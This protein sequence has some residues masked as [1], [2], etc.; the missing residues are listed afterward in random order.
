[1][2]RDVVWTKPRWCGVCKVGCTVVALGH[3]ASL[4][5]SFHLACGHWVFDKHGVGLGFQPRMR[6]VDYASSA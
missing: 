2:K 4:G 5:Q 1:M 3:S 6:L